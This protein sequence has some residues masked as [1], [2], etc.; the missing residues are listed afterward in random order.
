MVLGLVLSSR[1]TWHSNI[2]ATPFHHCN[3]RLMSPVTQATADRYNLPDR[4]PDIRT[5]WFNFVVEPARG[6]DP[7]LGANVAFHADAQING[8]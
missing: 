6:R 5:S 3:S 2:M 7:V 4:P 8:V 1:Y